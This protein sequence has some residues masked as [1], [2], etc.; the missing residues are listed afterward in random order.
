MTVAITIIPSIMARGNSATLLPTLRLTALNVYPIKSAAG[1]AVQEHS[2]DSF[3]LR[4]DRRFMVVNSAGR[5]ISQRTHP[6]MALVRP[7]IEGPQLRVS[8]PGM[9]S[10]EVS[11]SPSATDTRMV[12]IWDDACTALW[13]GEPAAA[14]FSQFLHCDCGLVYM[15]DQTVRPA[16]SRFAPEGAR[17]SFADAYP[18]LLISEES[19]VD[20]NTRL[21]SPILMNRFRPNLVIAGGEPYV[22][23][24]LQEFQ[25]GGIAFRGVKPCDRCVVTTTDQATTDRG[26]EPLRTLATYRRWDG[27][28]FFGQN[29]IHRGMG[30][31]RVGATLRV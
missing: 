23:D 22:E 19:L 14:W 18:F 3:G 9:P 1:L 29:L 25:L 28:V 30:S 10:L 13:L 21:P 2:V 12:E 17:V 7:S 5:M 15:P 11:L 8:A 4:H 24:R 6:R 27:K 26:P 20:L 31:L 16:D